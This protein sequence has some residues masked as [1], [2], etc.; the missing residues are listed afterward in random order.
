MS[1]ES[2]GAAFYEFLIAETGA[3]GQRGAVFT[4]ITPVVR[5]ARWGR[6]LDKISQA[7]VT[8][9]VSPGCFDA[10]C[11]ISTVI[12]E[13]RVKRNGE[14]VWEGPIIR[15]EVT[16][17]VRLV[18]F[19]L[20]WWLQK[21][22]LPDGLLV[23]NVLDVAQL[24]K[25]IVEGSLG[26]T[27]SGAPMDPAFADFVEVTNVGLFGSPSVEGDSYRYAFEE[28]QTWATTDLDW[29][30][31]KRSLLAGDPPKDVRFPDLTL[32][33]IEGIPKIIERGDLYATDV[34]TIGGDGRTV[35]IASVESVLGIR[36]P[37]HL[38]VERRE[39]IEAVNDQTAL[40]SIAESLVSLS[41][42]SPSE[43]T[44]GS[45][46][47]LSQKAPICIEQLIPG[48]VGW[49]DVTGYCAIRTRQLSEITEVKVQ[50][51]KKGE[52]VGFSVRPV[53]S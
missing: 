37:A 9:S 49:I 22:F 11:A 12:H 24:A 34:V 45:G 38:R 53:V 13:L 48:A 23:G 17:T 15:K 50:V 8:I 28:L 30:V 31:V 25:K 44:T 33:H 6:S 47:S 2:L 39:V 32:D 40:Q 29:T 21:R 41:Y 27:L 35:G 14:I 20:A 4:D 26:R 46:A 42:P 5:S 51:S 43:I 7:Q 36:V 52:K 1:G 19:D 10:V 16:G 3:D 18:A